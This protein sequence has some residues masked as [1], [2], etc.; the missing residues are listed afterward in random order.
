MGRKNDRKP[1]KPSWPADDYRR[2]VHAVNGDLIAI[3][4][5]AGDN[6]TAIEMFVAGCVLPPAERERAAY[7]LTRLAPEWTHDEAYDHLWGE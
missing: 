3:I 5:P 1:P 4:W 7:D 2:C 6:E